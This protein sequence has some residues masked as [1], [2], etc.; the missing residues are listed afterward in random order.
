MEHEDNLAQLL[1]EHYA[2]SPLPD[3]RVKEI[4]SECE[5][6]R[7][8]YRW[9]K[10]ALGASSLAAAAVITL[11]A[12][13]V[14][15]GQSA[16]NAPQIAATAPLPTLPE[17]EP[18]LPPEHKLV[19]VMIHS[20]EC[21]NSKAMVPVFSE[22]QEKL[23]GESVLFITFDYSSDCARHQAELLSKNLGLENIFKEYTSTGSLILVSSG[24]VRDV[25]G[26]G[27]SIA[28]AESA[29]RQHL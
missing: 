6:A 7:T 17:Y 26:Q 19:A 28:A 18:E 12:V 3:N 27:V 16:P 2:N 22:L 13:L 24:V 9:K 4:L 1:K 5:I 29:V 15:G 8:A 20:S 10:L 23:V 25:V 14:S 21:A 11:A